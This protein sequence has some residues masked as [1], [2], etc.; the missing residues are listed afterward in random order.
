MGVMVHHA[1]VA[2]TCD[3]Q[4]ANDFQGWLNQ[5]NNQLVTRAKAW[6]N[7]YISFAVLPDGS[8]EDWPESYDGDEFR[9]QVINRLE[10]DKYDDG[11]S[12]WDWVEVSFGEF[13]QEIVTG[14]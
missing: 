2:T 8:K 12:P 9:D 1:I 13:G 3:P 4:V 10:R 7:G 11:S 5:Q 14:G 6:T